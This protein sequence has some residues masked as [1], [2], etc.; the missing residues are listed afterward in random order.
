MQPRIH[1][2]SRSLIPLP[3]R[4]ATTALATARASCRACLPLSCPQAQDCS[5]PR[6]SWSSVT[7]HCSRAISR[8]GPAPTSRPHLLLYLPSPH[9]AYT[10]FM[11][12]SRGPPT[13]HVV[14]GFGVF[15]YAGPSSGNT[16][17]FVFS[18]IPSPVCLLMYLNMKTKCGSYEN[19]QL[20]PRAAGS[21]AGSAPR[22]HPT[23][24]ATMFT[25]MP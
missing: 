15:A 18:H 3:L 9:P 19:V 1:P 24:S 22:C 14:S 2:S 25:S 23:G 21:A 20:I 8:D 5:G 7:P 13:G 17:P 16:F 10:P 12:S 11:P 4:H 6:P